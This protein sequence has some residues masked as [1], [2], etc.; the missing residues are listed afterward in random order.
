M[1]TRHRASAICRNILPCVVALAFC[2]PAQAALTNLF[3]FSSANGTNY[4]SPFYSQVVLVRPPTFY[5]QSG[6]ITNASSGSYLTNGITNA[7]TFRVQWSVD[8]ANSNWITSGTFNPY[9]TNAE[10]D[11]YNGAFS[12]NVIYFRVQIIN[13]NALNVGIFQ[14]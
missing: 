6:G 1:K 5:F 12:S 9:T 3:N 2:L 13:S 14:Q 7:M 8:P 11:L 10:F 4:T